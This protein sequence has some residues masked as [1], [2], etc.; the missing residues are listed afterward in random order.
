MKRVLVL[1]LGLLAG[2]CAW[3][4][5][6]AAAVPAGP[7]MGLKIDH[8]T[9]SV[10][11][12]DA[13][14]AWLTKVFGFTVGHAGTTPTQVYKDMMLPGFRIDLLQFKGSSRPPVK[15]PTPLQQG[16]VHLVFL[17]PDLKVAQAQIQA[18]GIEIVPQK[19]STLGQVGF[20]FHDPEGNEFELFEYGH[21]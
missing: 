5:A 21:K 7:V 8:V 3:G 2:T 12:V 20:H 10:A 19:D 14:A 4:Q 6:P 11:D 15:T 16:F 17:V 9:F 13:E 1:G 18:M